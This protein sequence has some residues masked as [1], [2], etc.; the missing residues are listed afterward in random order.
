MGAPYD[1]ALEK[2]GQRI[3]LEESREL[4]AMFKQSL[5]H[6]TELSSSLRRFAN[7][8]SERRLMSA[9]ESVGKK[10]AQL[11]VV[12]VMFFLPALIILLGGPAMHAVTVGFINAN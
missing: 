7:D 4:A 2:W 12:M 10:S 9:R 1:T 11:T 3:G 6:G 5:V 8:L